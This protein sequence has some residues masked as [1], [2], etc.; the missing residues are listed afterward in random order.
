MCAAS[1]SSADASIALPF[2]L[3]LQ[4]MSILTIRLFYALKNKHDFSCESW[5]G[6]SNSNASICSYQVHGNKT[7]HEQ[8]CT[9]SA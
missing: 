9:C 3:L 8:P 2:P 6:Q 1:Y 7:V 5:L 4:R